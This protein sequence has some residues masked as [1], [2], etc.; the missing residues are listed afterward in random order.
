MTDLARAA[1]LPLANVVWPALF[2]ETR[3]L[4]PVVVLVGLWVEWSVLRLVLGLPAGRAL[5]A[6][7]SMNFVSTSIGLLAIPI[8]GIVY[9]AT[10]AQVVQ[11]VLGWNTFNPI[12]WGATFALGVL[13]NTGL[14]A[15]VLRVGFR[16][17]FDRRCAAWLASAN[18]VSVGLALLSVWIDPPRL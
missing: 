7:L 16:V 14:E 2:L 13:V 10:L 11:A 15:L 1:A 9:E 3:L 8:A 17:P 5:G 6:A 18:A 4:H 12:A